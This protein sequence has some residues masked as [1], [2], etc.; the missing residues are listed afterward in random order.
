MVAV[1]VPALRPAFEYLHFRLMSYL[2]QPFLPWTWYGL[3]LCCCYRLGNLVQKYWERCWHDDHQRF[4]V[5]FIC[6]YFW[7][8][9]T[10]NWSAI[11]IMA[12]KSHKQKIFIKTLWKTSM[13]ECNFLYKIVFFQNTSERLLNEKSTIAVK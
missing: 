4:S 13:M 11:K 6:I 7:C 12:Q 2:P 3:K 10:K 9:Q 1:R 5:I 8:I